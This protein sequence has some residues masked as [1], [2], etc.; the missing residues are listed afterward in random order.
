MYN[1]NV[2]LGEKLNTP[3][4]IVILSGG[5]TAAA[6]ALADDTIEFKCIIEFRMA[7]PSDRITE[8]MTNS[9]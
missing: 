3:P 8:R 5:G 4:T 2:F 9:I 1:Q 6:T 7:I